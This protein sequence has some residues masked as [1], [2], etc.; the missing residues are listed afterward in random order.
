MKKVTDFALGFSLFENEFLS[1]GF[2]QGRRIAHG[3]H[4]DA[5]FEEC[6]FGAYDIVCTAHS[7]R[8]LTFDFINYDCYLVL[9]P[10]YLLDHL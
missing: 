7:V 10:S 9:T 4:I 1:N 3:V 6:A 5:Y 8:F 2:I